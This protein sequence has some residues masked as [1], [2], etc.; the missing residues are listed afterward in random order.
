M[1]AAYRQYLAL[2]KE[3]VSLYQCFQWAGNKGD[4]SAGHGIFPFGINSGYYGFAAYSPFVAHAFAMFTSLS[5]E[6]LKVV[7][8][9]SSYDS[10]MLFET[11]WSL[12]FYAA[13]Q[14]EWKCFVENKN[15]ARGAEYPGST[16]RILKAIPEKRLLDPRFGKIIQQFP[17]TPK[18]EEMNAVLDTIKPMTLP[19]ETPRKY[20]Y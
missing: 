7:T 16:N 6:D 20:Y 13:G 10:Q 8:R 9:S 19:K 17:T 12:A 3:G 1:L 4:L 2:R 18:V 5:E 11:L 14:Y 15:P